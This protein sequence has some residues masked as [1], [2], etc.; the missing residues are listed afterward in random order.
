MDEQ[1]N[2]VYLGMPFPKV[3]ELMLGCIPAIEGREP[4]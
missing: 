4:R 3:K 2:L 1:G